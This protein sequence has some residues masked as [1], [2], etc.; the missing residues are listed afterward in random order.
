LQGLLFFICAKLELTL[1]AEYTLRV[2]ENSFLRGSNRGCR[3]L[4]MEGILLCGLFMMHY[5]TFQIRAGQGL[6]MGETRNLYNILFM[7]PER[8]TLCE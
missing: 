1:R 5:Y 2:S 8:R 7:K 6:L 3:K 4:H